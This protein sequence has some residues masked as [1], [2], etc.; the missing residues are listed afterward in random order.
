[1][2]ALCLVSARKDRDLIQD[3]F[4]NISFAEDQM[5][6]PNYLQILPLNFTNSPQSTLPHRIRSS[7]VF[8]YHF[9]E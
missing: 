9:L 2:L 3:Q 1:V 6:F 7:D 4:L 8:D 5:A